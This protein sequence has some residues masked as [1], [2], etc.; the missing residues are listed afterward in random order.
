MPITLIAGPHQSGKS[1]RLWQKLWAEKT[2]TAVLVRP[3][4]GIHGDLLRQMHAWGGSGLLPSVWSF[5]DLIERSAFTTETLPLACSPGWATH[6]VR[7]YAKSELRSVWSAVG[8]YRASG[9]ELADICLRLDAHGITEADFSLVER[10]LREKG[11]KDLLLQWYDVQKSLRHLEKVAKGND[12]LLPGARLRQLA[13]SGVNILKEAIYIDDFQT[14]S[15]A[16]LEFLKAVGS[17]RRVIISAIDDGRLGKGVSLADR[18]RSA[19]PDLEEERLPHIYP[20]APQAPALHQVIAGILD[21]SHRLDATPVDNYHYR[22]AMHAGRAIA[23]WLRRHGTAPAHALVVVRVA[24]A[25]ALVLADSLI[26][27]EVPVRGNF[28]VPFLSTTAGGIF[29]ALATYCR[30]PNWGHFIGLLERLS[31]EEPPV[32][33]LADIN[34]PWA[35]LPIIEGFKRL[36]ELVA[37]GITGNWAWQEPQQKERPWLKA[38]QIWLQDWHER[39]Q[40]TGTW[41]EQLQLLSAQ[42]DI[43]DGQ[44]G[45][46]RTLQELDVIHPI[47]GEDLDDILQAAQ[48]EVVRDGGPG[49]LEITDAIRGRTMP[50]PV[51]FIHDLEHGRWPSQ[52]TGGAL[53][54]L[55]ERRLLSA[56]LDRDIFDEAGRAS[57]EM[58]AFLAVVARATQTVV[59][60]IPCGE[61]EANAWLGTLCDQLQWDLEALRAQV[62]YEAVPGAPLGKHDAQGAHE[63]ALWSTTPS[64]PHFTFRVPPT[65]VDKL[66]IK[67]SG[68]SAVFKDS[69]ALVCDRLCLSEPLQDREL[70]EEGNELHKLLEELIKQ[71]PSAWVSVLEQL[72]EKWIKN[73][74]DALTQAERRRLAKRV[75]G[76]IELEA[77]AVADVTEFDA[78]KIITVPIPIPMQ[79]TLTLRGK[80]DRIDHLLD[81]SVRLIDYKRGAISDQAAHLAQGTD[82]QLLGYLLAA[83]AEQLDPSGAY[84]LSLRAGTRAGWGTIPTP[85]GKSTSKMGIELSTLEEAAH[86]LG[87]CIA[88]LAAGT[89]IADPAGRSASDYAPIARLDEQRLHTGEDAE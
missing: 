53:L 87:Q 31:N 64:N 39:L 23:A 47:S 71:P 10:A 43:S 46:L 88:D 17:N 14:F 16:E 54:P 65:Q 28:H 76:V 45:V 35:R 15:P 19:M 34:G 41:W 9:K 50:R 55:D 51:V 66:G 2:G 6:V 48:V 5:N 78:E 25:S 56:L 7:A 83:K 22:D 63:R 29:N 68:L 69:F 82:G 21:E 32:I 75:K 67:V 80:I 89:A 84:Y 77:L 12:Y 8:G 60:G 74:E 58:A 27:A 40:V 26:A 57:G 59:F 11:K 72:L 70:M 33:R 79:T 42:L 13:Q 85:G 24:D 4:A 20:S 86:S 61:R 62:A 73:A 3:Q 1:W 38:T 44:S 81:G 37:Q 49:S 30:S 52:P 36:D 18:I